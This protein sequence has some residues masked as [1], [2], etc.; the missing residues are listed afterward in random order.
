LI[1]AN[2]ATSSGINALAVS[3]NAW[4]E[5]TANYNNAPA[6][7]A[8]LASSG[9]ITTGAWATLDVTSYVTAEGTYSFAVITSGAT[10]VSLAARETGANAPQL[11]LDLGP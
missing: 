2:S 1:F 8:A 4:G 5:L 7:G 10:A 11:F 9:A 3:D 6:L